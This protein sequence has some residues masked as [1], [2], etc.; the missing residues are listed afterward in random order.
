M[1]DQN[2]S[3]ATLTSTSPFLLTQTRL[4][5]MLRTGDLQRIAH[6]IQSF[7]I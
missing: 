5:N 6:Y 2:H 1:D 7:G 3:S 4:G